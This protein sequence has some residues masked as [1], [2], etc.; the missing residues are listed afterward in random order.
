MPISF[1]STMPDERERVPRREMTAG[2]SLMHLATRVFGSPLMITR[3]KMDVILHVLGARLNLADIPQVEA[4]AL[5]VEARRTSQKFIPASSNDNKPYRVTNDG[6]AVVD[7]VGTLVRRTS[8]LDALSGLTSYDQLEAEIC[9]ALRDPAVRGVLC[10]YDS[11]GGEV[12]G[13]FDLCDQINALSGSK[14]LY[15]SVCDLAASAA[16]A[17]A[18]TADRIYLTQTA[19]VGSVGVF[20]L[21]A[22]TSE[23]D[24]EMGIKYTYI[25]NGKGKV[26]GNPHQPLSDSALETFQSEI[27]RTYGMFVDAVAQHRRISAS[28]IRDMGAA[29]K[30]GQEAIPTGYADAIGTPDQAMAALRRAVSKSS[31]TTTRSRAQKQIQEE[32][33]MPAIAPHKT[34]TTDE[35]WD[36]GANEKR[37]REG[38]SQS[39]YEKEYAW[40]DPDKDA[41]TKSAYDF[42]HHMV[43]ESGEIGAANIKACQSGIGILNGGRGGWT[44]SDRRG[45]YKHLSKHLKDAGLEAPPL[46]SDAEMSAQMVLESLAGSTPGWKI[47]GVNISDLN[48]GA[49]ISNASFTL[50]ANTTVPDASSTSSNAG[51]EAAV[52]KGEDN[53]PI[54]TTKEQTTMATPSADASTENA[55]AATTHPAEVTPKDVRVSGK[56]KPAKTKPANDDDGDGDGND[57]EDDDN[58]KAYQQIEYLC[59]VA[60]MPHMAADFVL[61]YPT[62]SVEDVRKRLLAAK[63]ARE[64]ANGGIDHTANVSVV[65]TSTV[66]GG[67]V[68]SQLAGDKQAKM[69]EEMARTRAAKEGIPYLKAYELVM[70]E[71]ASIYAEYVREKMTAYKNVEPTTVL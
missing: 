15:A 30:W 60:G 40:R 34:S 47:E 64:R 28:K 54:S 5:E 59:K 32:D 38:E 67:V 36:G 57:D 22:E 37:L 68:V 13:L 17:L 39:Y 21:H 69:L 29:I 35:P 43:S 46:K 65:G 26:D 27:D 61:Q 24:K 8:G 45:I 1:I 63:G 7:V 53:S 11:P 55:S 52:A 48:S 70:K 10:L 62:V 51:G 44:G 20:A 12:S 3:E 19:G 56:G 49:I 71:N 16:F 18:T 58:M 25:Y 31:G 23:M 41:E 33:D 2:G 14:P 66:N 4:A 42:P 6:I 50:T 9:G